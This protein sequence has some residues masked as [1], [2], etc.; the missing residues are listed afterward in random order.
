MKKIRVSNLA[1]S[2]PESYVVKV[3]AE[4]LLAGSGKNGG[5]GGHEDAE[6]DN[7]EGQGTG[8]TGGHLSAPD[9]GQPL[10]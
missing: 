7:D 3:E 10:T 4:A 8:G 2:K 9:D 1:Y 5:T 6:D